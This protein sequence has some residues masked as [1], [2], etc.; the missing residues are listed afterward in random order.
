MKIVIWGAGIRGKRIYSKLQTEDVVAFIDTDKDKIGTEYCGKRVITLEEYI[1]QYAEYFILITPRKSEEI[2]EWL[3]EKDIERYFDYADC[4]QELQF[5]YER[6]ILEEY[7]DRCSRLDKFGIYGSGFYS[8]Y[9]YDKMQK[10]GCKD[11]YLIPEE[12]SDINKIDAL[13]SAFEFLHVIR[14]TDIEKYDV[15]K[16][17]IT[18]GGDSRKK[19][20]D[21]KDIEI[22]DAFHLLK[23]NPQYKNQTLAKFRDIHL[24]QRCFIVAT[25]PSL[26]MEDL[27]TI[28]KH[29]EISIGMNK[30]YLAFALSEWRPD[31]YVIGDVACIKEAEKE[32]KSLPVKNVLVSD[33]KSGFWKGEI[34]ANIYRFHNRFCNMKREV[35]EFSED[36]TMGIFNGGTVTYNCIQLAAYLGCR[37]IILLGVDFNFSDNYNDVQNHFIDTYYAP[38]SKQGFFWKDESLKAYTAAKIYAENHGIKIYNAT[39]GGKLEVFERVNFDDLF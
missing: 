23:S 3:D 17:F 35:L 33:G 4:P 8:I 24:G 11:I 14:C 19:I 31:Y 6:D 25:G 15:N 26:T 29:K 37:E 2:K 5:E 9:F 18:V 12:E 21:N 10:K 32:I 7:L 28:R 13:K 1:E 39:R 34:P 16:I 38:D 36:I 30:I 27:D 22:E 20:T